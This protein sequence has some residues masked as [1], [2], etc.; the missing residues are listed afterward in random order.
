MDAMLAGMAAV[1]IIR[2]LAAHYR[3]NLPKAKL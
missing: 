3:W 1:V 2:C